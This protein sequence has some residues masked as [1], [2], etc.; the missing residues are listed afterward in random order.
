MNQ[1]LPVKG[2]KC[3]WRYKKTLSLPAIREKEF[4]FTMRH[5]FTFAQLANR[6]KAGRACVHARGLFCH[7]GVRLTLGHLGKQPA[8]LVRLGSV[9]SDPSIPSAISR[10]SEMPVD[11]WAVTF[12]AAL[13]TLAEPGEAP[14][15]QDRTKQDKRKSSCSQPQG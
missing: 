12:T 5:H 11:S 6:K 1:Q 13:S 4:F 2:K 15:G 14:R 8:L 3:Q 9:C 7:L 10:Q